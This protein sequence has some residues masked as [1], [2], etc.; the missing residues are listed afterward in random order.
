MEDD[1]CSMSGKLAHHD[2]LSPLIGEEIAIISA[3]KPTGQLVG[4]KVD[5]M[6]V[7]DEGTQKT[8]KYLA[9]SKSAE[10]V[11][12]AS[13]E[14]EPAPVEEEEE[15]PEA[16]PEPKPKPEPAQQ[17][18]AKTKAPLKDKAP[19][20]VGSITPTEL[21]Y[22]QTINTGNYCSVKIG[23]TVSLTDGASPV[24]ALEKCRDFIAKHGPKAAV[25]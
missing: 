10:I 17:D 11:K 2:D 16:K 14:E 25:D 12:L 8:V 6:I 24:E 20:S 18:M 3:K 5:E 19:E 9:V 7:D 13:T 4:V 21:R 1:T 23:L 22:D 15:V